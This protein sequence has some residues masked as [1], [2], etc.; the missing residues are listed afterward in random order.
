MGIEK[1][2]F[3]GGLNSD[4][5]DRL[6][7]NGDYRFALNVRASKSDGA[8]QG[9]IENT[10][11]NTIVFVTLPEGVNKVIGALDNTVGN[12]VIY[13]VWNDLENHSIFEY[14]AT[15][16]SV[17]LLLRSP[18][19]NFKHNKYIND[20]TIVGGSFFFNDRV[21]PPR[22]LNIERARNNEYPTPFLEEYMNVIVKAP[23]FAPVANYMDDTPITNPGSLNVSGNTNN[24]RGKLFQ[25]RYKWVYLDDEQSAWSPISKVPLPVNESIYRPAGY[26]PLHLNNHINVEVNLGGDYVKRV[27]I[28]ARE[29]NTGDF[30]LIEDFDKAKAGFSLPFPDDWSYDFYNDEV[31]LPI[32]N[33]GNSG[34]RLFDNVPQLADSMSQIDGNKIAFGGVTEGYDPVDVDMDINLNISNSVATKTSMAWR[35]IPSAEGYHWNQGVGPFTYCWHDDNEVKDRFRTV[36]DKK[37]VVIKA[38]SQ[39]YA[40][41][42]SSNQYD[43][44]KFTSGNPLLQFGYNTYDSWWQ[45]HGYWAWNRYAPSPNVTSNPVHDRVMM[46]DHKIEVKQKRDGFAMVSGS[47]A[48][49]V[50]FGAPQSVGTR[51]VLKINLGYRPLGTSAD[52]TV[53]HKIVKFQYVSKANDTA[54]TVADAFKTKLGDTGTLHENYVDIRFIHSEV[55]THSYAISAPNPVGTASP[56]GAHNTVPTDEALLRIKGEAYV[57]EKHITHD[58]WFATSGPDIGAV[59]NMSTEI[60]VYGAWTLENNKSLKSGATHGFGLVY[61]DDENRSGLTNVSKVMGERKVYLPFFGDR[62]VW[63]TPS[64]GE[65][66]DP[67]SVTLTI[68]H[69]APA[70]AKR[71]QVVY[72]G[73]QTVSYIPG[74]SGYKGFIQCQLKKVNENTVPSGNAVGAINATLD[75]IKDYNE[76]V[77]EN[78]DLSY[79]FNKGDRMRFMTRPIWDA[80]KPPTYLDDTKDVEV[81]SYDPTSRIIQFKDPQIAVENNMMIEIYTP[82]KDSE[83]P[84]YREVGECYP[85]INGMHMGNDTNQLGT[86]PAK[87]VLEDVGDVYLRYRTAPV[88]C[89]IESYAYS[90]FYPSDS[91]DK[92]RPNIVDNNITKT[93]RNSTIRYSNNYIPETNINGLSQFDDFDFKQ[94]DEQYGDI[95]RMYSIDKDLVIFQNL[96]VGRVRIGQTTLYGNEGTSIATVKSQN[97]VLSDVVYATGEFGI[98]KNPESFAVYGNRKYFVDAARG[99]VLRLSTD[100]LTPISEYGMH[101]YFT[102]KL[103]EVMNAGGDF[104]LFGE[105]D[106][107]FDEYVLSIQGD[108]SLR[109]GADVTVDDDGDSDLDFDTFRINSGG[110][111]VRSAGVTGVITDA[112][113]MPAKTSDTTGSV[114]SKVGLGGGGAG[115]VD[116]SGGGPPKDD[117]SG[118]VY[119]PATVFNPDA[120]KE[121]IAFSEMK[122]KWCT[123]YSYIPDYLVNNNSKLLSFKD[124]AIYKHND[125]LTYNNF[126]QKQFTSKLKLISNV[127]P[128]VIKVYNSVFLESNKPWSFPSITNQF[129]QESSL[130][131]ED[132][133]DDEGVFKSNFLK[134][135]NT[136]NVDLPLI[137]GDD[138]RCHSM[139]V[140]MENADTE[141]VKMFSVGINLTPSKLTNN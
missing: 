46:I 109:L 69:F 105:Y 89:V 41:Q 64:G 79:S 120:V 52:N 115:D 55:S 50:I 26:Y 90:D 99:V 51:Y 73:N 112:D 141:E 20:A 5:E 92:G 132:F 95:Q 60:N 47:V 27:K 2:N 133:V 44:G 137:E 7:P 17:S 53:A 6:V 100:G 87:V 11:G 62:K 75:N 88:S 140:E 108:I 83:D 117:G 94:Y 40:N 14:D 111:I 106:M 59:H 93:K 81:I 71:Y 37:Y 56:N 96:K 125:N 119:V 35:P 103:S 138:L 13:C 104:K 84:V 86:I 134:D 76:N 28:A 25:F 128:S 43:Y 38:Q 116:G 18:L 48:N 135:S 110:P 114:S 123:F 82:K 131:V 15:T 130:I 22:S 61:Y 70:W 42:N 39:E 36:G 3:I 34:M 31:L 74:I 19:L 12:T 80:T 129:K 66:P 68:K 127:E 136:P 85:I 58:G 21:N 72:T 49:E 23:G 57:P 4:V 122:K 98:G 118:D 54:I 8:S 1:K 77:P 91:W 139:T 16:S 63:Y 30:L 113:G 107:R 124:G 126:Y 10:K 78:V 24:V 101:N 33:D 102:D 9:A 97:A 29:G 67:T 45:Q 65:V 32:D 121:T